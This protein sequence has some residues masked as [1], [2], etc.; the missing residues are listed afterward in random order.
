MATGTG[1]T[2]FSAGGTWAQKSYPPVS[3]ESAQVWNLGAWVARPVVKQVGT[4]AADRSAH[5]FALLSP[6]TRPRSKGEHQGELVHGC[7]GGVAPPRARR[8]SHWPLPCCLAA[9]SWLPCCPSARLPDN[10]T[11]RTSELSVQSGHTLWSGVRTAD[12]AAD[13]SDWWRAPFSRFSAVP[14]AEREP[15]RPSESQGCYMAF[16]QNADELVLG[17]VI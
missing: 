7:K 2:G 13:K 4:R 3:V 11:T 9:P 12:A 10:A 15:S 16:E 5:G 17:L 6:T 14:P 8:I 1:P